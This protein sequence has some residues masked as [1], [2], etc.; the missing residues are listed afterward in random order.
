MRAKNRQLLENN[1]KVFAGKVELLPRLTGRCT[2]M[3]MTERLR[4][5]ISPQK[6]KL[7]EEISVN[8][9]F[10]LRHDI[11]EGIYETFTEI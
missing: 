11:N 1:K 9:C 5:P 4:T 8:L 7:A 2:R 6:D 3:M 10:S